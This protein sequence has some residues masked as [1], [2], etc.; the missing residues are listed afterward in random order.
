MQT[1]ALKAYPQE[2]NEIRE[3]LIFKWFLEGIEVNQVR[4]DLK[5]NLSDAEITLDKA[6]ERALHIEAVTTIEE[7]NNEPRVSSI[8]S[9]ENTQLVYSIKDLVQTLQTNQSNRGGAKKVYARR[10]TQFKKTIIAITEAA[11]MIYE[12]IAIVERNRQDQEARTQA[13]TGRTRVVP[14][15][16]RQRLV[17]REKMSP[18]RSAKSCIYGTLWMWE[19]K[20]FQKKLPVFKRALAED[21]RASFSASYVITLRG[22]HSPVEA[23]FAKIMI[24][25]KLIM[26]LN[27]SGSNINFLSDTLYQ[28]LEPARSDCAINVY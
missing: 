3:N 5:K 28:Q 25:D 19:S 10:W 14:S 21:G 9:I 8:Q 16:Q 18:L 27:D 26:A 1:L 11:L 13:E 20:L 24:K 7:E 22:G 12:P 4:L 15:S 2:S 17:L 6:L 23:L